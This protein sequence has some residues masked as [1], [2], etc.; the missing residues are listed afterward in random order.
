MVFADIGGLDPDS[1]SYDLDETRASIG[2]GFG[3]SYPFPI[4]LTFGFPLRDGEGD[5]KRVFAFS[6]GF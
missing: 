5:D 6:I 1:F 4:L 3:M 2:F